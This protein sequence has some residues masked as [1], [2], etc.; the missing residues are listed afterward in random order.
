MCKQVQ[1]SRD[2]FVCTG[3]YDDSFCSKDC[4]RNA[5]NTHRF[6]CFPCYICMKRVSG[7][8]VHRTCACIKK[9]LSTPQWKTA[10]QESGTIL[11]RSGNSVSFADDFCD[12]T[13]IAI[14]QYFGGFFKVTIK[15]SIQSDED[16]IRA[17]SS[18]YLSTKSLWYRIRILYFTV[19]RERHT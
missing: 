16:T 11:V 9:V 8:K 18:T 3:C 13:A 4:Q 7:V 19:S 10:E 12:G 15:S 2:M 14:T 1:R 6:D 17:N 5:W